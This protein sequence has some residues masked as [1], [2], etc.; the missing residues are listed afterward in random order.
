MTFIGDAGCWTTPCG[1]GFSFVVNNYK[2]YAKHLL[3][4]FKEEKFD[5]KH[6]AHLVKL[7]VRTKSQIL[8]DQITTHFLANASAPMLDKFIKLFEVGGPL[9]DKGPLL[10]EK[11]F[12]LTLS[13]DDVKFMLKVAVKYFDLRELMHIMPYKDY[14][15]LLEEVKEYVEAEVVD[16]LNDLLHVFRKNKTRSSL[17]NGFDFS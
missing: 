2:I 11:L 6:L 16:G 3:D 4:S 7:S 10:C 13:D 12:T 17:K 5:K 9:G 1:W 14:F 15:L 8:I